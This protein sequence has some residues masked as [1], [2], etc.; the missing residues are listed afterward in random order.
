MCVASAPNIPPP[1]PPPAIP[2]APTEVNPSVAA[3]RNRARVQ[4]AASSGFQSTIL[5]SGRGVT[6][7]A[8]TAA[9]TL[10]G[11]RSQS[12]G[13]SV[14]RSG[15]GR[16]G[17]GRSGAPAAAPGPTA[18][19]S[20]TQPILAPGLDPGFDEDFF[21]RG[22]RQFGRLARSKGISSGSL[23]GGSG[24]LTSGGGTSLVTSGG[25]GFFGGGGGGSSGLRTLIP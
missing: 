22:G 1:P 15:V 12:Q 5:T 13:S 14:G 25:G 9:P 23:I 20:S 10:F 6:S 19:P 11:S 18:A 8:G 17:V 21:R 2:Q 24:T 7:A 3:A 4:A 16:S